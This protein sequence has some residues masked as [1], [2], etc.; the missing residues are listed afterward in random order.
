[1]D[2][3]SGS[4]GPY[5][6]LKAKT[7]VLMVCAGLVATWERDPA[8]RRA[9]RV[10]AVAV[11]RAASEELEGWTGSTRVRNPVLSTLRWASYCWIILGPFG[12]QISPFGTLVII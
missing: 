3:E 12:S 8:C 11:G 4:E 10:R 1:V 7:T 5:W 9:D 6:Q 2:R